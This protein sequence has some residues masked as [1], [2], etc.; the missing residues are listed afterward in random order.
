MVGWAVSGICTAAGVITN[1][2]ARTDIGIDSRTGFA[3][4]FWLKK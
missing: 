2:K 1:E 4:L 3:S